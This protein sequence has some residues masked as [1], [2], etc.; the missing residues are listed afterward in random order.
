M[1]RNICWVQNPLSRRF[2]ASSFMA[3]LIALPVHW[4]PTL[5]S[6]SRAGGTLAEARCLGMAHM[7]VLD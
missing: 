4:I 3:A 5:A 6:S 2:Q 1:G 7:K